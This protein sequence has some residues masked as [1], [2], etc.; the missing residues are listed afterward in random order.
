MMFNRPIFNLFSLG[1]LGGLCACAAATDGR[2]APLPAAHPGYEARLA[3]SFEPN[4]GQAD[5]EI[6]FLSR[7]R[8]YTLLLRPHEAVLRLR[9]EKQAAPGTDDRALAARR[10]PLRSGRAGTTTTVRMRLLG[11]DPQAEGELVQPLAGRVNY[12]MGRDSRRWKKGVPTYGQVR[13]TEVYSGIDLV[14]YGREGLLEYDFV[15][16]PGADPAAIRLAFDGLLDTGGRPPLEVDPQGALVLHTA[17]GEIRKPRP[18]VYQEVAGKRVPV[19]GDYVLFPTG[20]ARSPEVGF[21]LARYDRT[22]PLVIDPVIVYSTYLGGSRSENFVDADIRLSSIAADA[23]GC[24]FVLGTTTS[25]DFPVTPGAYQSTYAGPAGGDYYGDLFVAKFSPD[26]S[27]LVYATYLGGSGAEAGYDIAIDGSGNAYVT[28]AT[29]SNDFPVL[30]AVQAQRST[31]KTSPDAPDAFVAKLNAEGSGLVFSTYL[32]A[33]EPDGGRC[34]TVSNQGEATVCG[35]TFDD[36]EFPIVNP[37]QGSGDGGRGDVF[38]ARFTP[39]GD[40]LAYSSYLGGNNGIDEPAGMAVDGAGNVYIVGT[41]SVPT[42]DS[43]NFPTLNAVQPFFGG[44]FND[45]FVSKVSRAGELIYSTY[46]GGSSTD[47]GK[48]I[49]VDPLG[50]AYVTGYISSKDFPQAEEDHT[51]FGSGQRYAC[52]VK[53][54]PEGNGL[55][56]TTFIAAN[57]GV[58]IGLRADGHV[59]V[60]G[61]TDRTYPIRTE[62]PPNFARG[63]FV[64]RLNPTG[65]EIVSTSFILASAQAI[66]VDALGNMYLT[67]DVFLKNFETANALQPK[68]A[69]RSNRRTPK[70]EITD[71]F[72]AKITSAY[73]PPGGRLVVTPRKLNFGNVKLGSPPVTRRL[74]IRNTGR[75]FI[76][77]LVGWTSPP[78]IVPST[79][80]EFPLAPGETREVEV[81]FTPPAR[82][83]FSSKL[84]ITST[85]PRKRVLNVTLNGRGK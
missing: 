70:A 24:A 71:A 61:D 57:L 84:A 36:F 45:F 43:N 42:K 26:G 2:A 56:Y 4:L 44:G 15:V 37:F 48:G 34:I 54:N 32:G 64:A 69:R 81:S 67:G 74:R 79:K 25:A 63:T 28:G 12:L 76:A 41:T 47:F 55:V 40:T 13:Y 31:S 59:Y 58:D 30:N 51:A 19:Q 3:A 60:V 73:V 82:G 27:Q 52:V 77:A 62:M 33:P 35:I 72:V 1:M 11:A 85:D 80:T 5:R 46:L 14:Y 66:A 38:V 6:Q 16:A 39:A 10:D 23:E 83:R 75:E 20:D 17:E 18:T 78:F 53:L 68:A 9:T 29:N 21:R 65:T 7:G 8:G 22:R 49:A 50:N